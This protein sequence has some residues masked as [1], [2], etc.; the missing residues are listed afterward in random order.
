[1]K[2]A[3]SQSNSFLGAFWTNEVASGTLV[4]VFSVCLD[5][6]FGGLE[7]S[8]SGMF[9]ALIPALLKK[10]VGIC[11][12]KKLVAVHFMHMHNAFATTPKSSFR[13]LFS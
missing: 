1:L 8:F 13:V 7:G 9:D 11:E 3:I 6:L 5:C 2:S 12:L 10:K 4:E